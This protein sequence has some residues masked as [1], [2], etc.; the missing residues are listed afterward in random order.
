MRYIL[1]EERTRDSPKKRTRERTI[2][3]TRNK[4]KGILRDKR[5]LH[6][7]EGITEKRIRWA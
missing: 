7:E 5:R 4:R 3:R 2:R 6:R 1:Y